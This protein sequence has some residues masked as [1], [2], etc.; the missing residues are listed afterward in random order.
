MCTCTGH[1]HISLYSNTE[2]QW[3]DLGCFIWIRS[4]YLSVN[5][6]WGLYYLDFQFTKL[7]LILSLLAATCLCCGSSFTLAFLPQSH[8]KAT[9]LRLQPLSPW[10]WKAPSVRVK[11]VWFYGMRWAL[12][13][14]SRQQACLGEGGG[15]ASIRKM[16]WRKPASESQR[17]RNWVKA[18][19]SLTKH[20]YFYFM[21]LFP[22]SE[23]IN[24]QH[25]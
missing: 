20:W 23:I 25:H 1:A 22:F 9:W 3:Q 7:L 24:L 15:G 8:M 21:A 10:R 14:R 13:P 6:S 17:W 19:S 2:T 18:S 5:G 12:G 4:I 11:M 16:W